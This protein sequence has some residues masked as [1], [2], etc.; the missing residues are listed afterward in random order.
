MSL[1][2]DPLAAHANPYPIY[3]R[4]YPAL[5]GTFQELAEFESAAA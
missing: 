5:R 2:F 3:Q 4:L 1:E